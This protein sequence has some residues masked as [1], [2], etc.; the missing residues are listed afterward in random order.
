MPFFAVFRTTA[1][2]RECEDSTHF[3]PHQYRCAEGGLLRNV[4]ATVSIQH[5]WRLAIFD[6]VALAHD[7]HRDSGA[8]LALVEDLLRDERLRIG[9][10]LGGPEQ[11]HFARV[12]VQSRDR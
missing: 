1:N 8:I 3:Q 12:H 2:V 4:E 5:Q 11:R 10:I 6:E 9:W 7:E